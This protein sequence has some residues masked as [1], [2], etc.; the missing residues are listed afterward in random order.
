MGAVAWFVFGFVGFS[1]LCPGWFREIEK[2]SGWEVVVSLVA[3]FL[4]SSFG[5]LLLIPGVIKAIYRA[6]VRKDPN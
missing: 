3:V 5:V 1:L 4:L 6:S 2:K